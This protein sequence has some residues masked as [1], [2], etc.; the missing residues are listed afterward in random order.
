M[1]QVLVGLFLLLSLASNAPASVIVAPVAGT[2]DLGGPGFG[3]LTDTFNQ[4]GLSVGYTSGVTNFDTYI[5]SNPTHTFVSAGFEWFSN[6]GTGT[7]QNPAQVTYDLGSV[8]TIDRMALWNEDASGIGTLDLYTSTDG[9]NFTPL[10][11]GLLP[12]DN[13]FAAYGAD[14][15]SFAAT[16]A[17]YVRLVMTDSP[18]PNPGSFDAAA[19]GEVAFRI[20]EIQAVPEP[21]TLAVFSLMALGGLGITRRR[22]SVA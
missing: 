4:S 20:G 16:N 13:L 7:D 6:V 15:F 5:G 21:T 10:A 17:R 3:S 12:T 18:Q 9:T 22:K 8:M 1:R 2:I 14:V 19:I 11:L